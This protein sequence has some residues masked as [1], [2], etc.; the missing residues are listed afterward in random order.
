MPRFS[1]NFT[2]EEL[3][4]CVVLWSYSITVNKFAFLIDKWKADSEKLFTKEKQLI[5]V[6]KG[7]N[8]EYFQVV[9]INFMWLS[10]FERK[11]WISVLE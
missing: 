2:C 11:V 4:A 3:K 1:E 10:I 9:Y 6:R 7:I 8:H 5:Y